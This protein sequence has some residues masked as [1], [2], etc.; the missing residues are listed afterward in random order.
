[1]MVSTS[2]FRSSKRVELKFQV[3]PWRKLWEGYIWH[4]IRLPSPWQE[5]QSPQA[6]RWMINKVASLLVI[7][8]DVALSRPLNFIPVTW[9]R[10]SKT[11][12]F[13]Q[14]DDFFAQIQGQKQNGVC[15]PKF[16]KILSC[17]D[18]VLETLGNPLNVGSE[19]YLRPSNGVDTMCNLFN[20]QIRFTLGYFKFYPLPWI[21]I[22][23]KSFFLVLPDSRSLVIKPVFYIKAPGYMLDFLSLRHHIS[24]YI[25]SGN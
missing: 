18:G 11:L 17:R 16:T 5:F 10:I 13:I 7:T 19:K 9:I 24:W 14:L 1:M 6:V 15:M 22:L 4:R 20:F 23:T 12:W 21:D 8:A 25:A 2:K 3:K